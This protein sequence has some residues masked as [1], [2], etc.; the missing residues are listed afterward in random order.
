MCWSIDKPVPAA[1]L[2]QALTICAAVWPGQLAGVR[3]VGY[4]LMSGR[5][6]TELVF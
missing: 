3:Q 2:G 6:V 5:K 1:S 4:G